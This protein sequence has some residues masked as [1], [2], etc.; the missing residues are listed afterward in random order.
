MKKQ[1]RISSLFILLFWFFLNNAYAQTFTIDGTVIKD[2]CGQIF[3]PIGANVNG[4]NFFEWGCPEYGYQGWT[5][6]QQ[7]SLFTAAGKD[8]ILNYWKFNFLR[9]GIYLKDAAWDNVT[10]A[11]GWLKSPLTIEANMDKLVNTYTPE[12][13]VVMFEV[14]DFTGEDFNN[15]SANDFANLTNFWKKI[16]ARYK[17]NTY[18]WF[19]LM[20]EPGAYKNGSIG[21]EYKVRHR[22]LIQVIRN[23]GANNIIVVDGTQWGQDVYSWSNESV[24]ASNSGILTYGTDI[25]AGFNNVCFNIHMYDQWAL[26]NIPHNIKLRD[27]I[28]KV[29]EKGLCLGFIGEVGTNNDVNKNKATECAYTVGLKEK[30]IG[31]VSWHYQEKDGYSL[32][33]NNGQDR[34]GWGDAVNSI[35]NP[36]NLSQYDGFYFWKATH[37]DGFGKRPDC[38]GG[39]GGNAQ[40]Q[41][42]AKGL[43][44]TEAISLLVNDVAVKSW[45]LSTTMVSYSYE[46]AVAGKNIKVAFTNDGSYTDVQIDYVIVSGVTKQAEAQLV[47]TGVWNIAQNRCGGAASEW[48]NCN[49]YIDFGTTGAPANIDITVRARGTSG[50]ETIALQADNITVKTFTLAT[51]M[52]NYLYTGAVGGKNIKVVFTNDASN[53]DVQIDYAVIAGSIKQAEV[54]TNNTGAWNMTLSKCGGV[55]SEWLSCNGYIDFGTSASPNA[56]PVFNKV[57]EHIQQNLFKTS[58]YPNPA[59]AGKPVIRIAGELANRANI[60][61]T[62]LSGRTIWS[63]KVNTNTDI[64]VPKKLLPGIYLVNVMVGKERMV[65]RLLVTD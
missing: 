31:M 55:S 26:G 23:E 61:I 27:Y 18:V 32:C 49:G 51:G 10:Y 62:D 3:V 46:G 60:I 21:V 54:Q 4:G 40:L 6:Y 24:N 45:T 59:K 16:A 5:K 19:N 33:V 8:K 25:K 11:D 36:T 17:N 28:D 41:I 42:R 50:S 64:I 22:E 39:G 9:G 48:M 35:A 53:R 14:H 34:S 63:S 29:R 30:N 47:N 56:A 57:E 7:S 43:A 20:N 15:A 58:I 65:H 12:K 2:P 44:G 1:V 38:T 52:A 13:V 37:T